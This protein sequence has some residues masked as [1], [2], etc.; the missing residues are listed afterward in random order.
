M[1]QQDQDVQHIMKALVYLNASLEAREK[2]LAAATAAAQ[3]PCHPQ[4]D[5][6]DK[7]DMRLMRNIGYLVPLH[8]GHN[9]HFSDAE[10]RMLLEHF[11]KCG[12]IDDNLFSG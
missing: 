6:N 4:D 1:L 7:D 12:W 2:Y 3:H 5:K 10:K 8:C 9:A 11:V